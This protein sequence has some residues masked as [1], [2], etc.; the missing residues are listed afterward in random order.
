MKIYILTK[1]A[2]MRFSNGTE[3]HFNDQFICICT[4]LDTAKRAIDRKMEHDANFREKSSSNGRSYD[5]VVYAREYVDCYG[6]GDSVIFRVIEKEIDDVPEIKENED[7]K[8]RV[9]DLE[10]KID[11]LKTRLNSLTGFTTKEGFHTGPVEKKETKS[12]VKFW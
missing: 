2:T 9:K 10:K 6:T 4:D 11:G 8:K 1:D 3:L 5:E 7:L 12:N